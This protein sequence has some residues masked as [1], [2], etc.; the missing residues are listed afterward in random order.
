MPGTPFMGH[1]GSPH[2]PKHRSGQTDGLSG[3][4]SHDGTERWILTCR[5]ADSL[6]SLTV[7]RDAVGYVCWLRVLT[8]W[9]TAC[10]LRVDCL[11]WLCVLTAAVSSEAGSSAVG[12]FFQW[13]QGS[14]HMFVFRMNKGQ[15]CSKSILNELCRCCHRLNQTCTGFWHMSQDSCWEN[16]KDWIALCGDFWVEQMEAI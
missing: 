5:G 3:Q 12:I 7:W 4:L 2:G 8:A 15:F 11:C 16:H 13:L 9:V 10:W 1:L 6:C 14:S